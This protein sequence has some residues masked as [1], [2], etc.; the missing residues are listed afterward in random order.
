MVFGET[1]RNWAIT[2]GYSYSLVHAMKTAG[3]SDSEIAARCQKTYIPEDIIRYGSTD[4]V[5]QTV[6]IME[7]NG[8]LAARTHLFGLHQGMTYSRAEQIWDRITLGH[9]T[10]NTFTYENWKPWKDDPVYYVSE[11]GEVARHFL[12]SGLFLRL[13]P[14]I[15]KR[16]R[17]AGG[18][19]TKPGKRQKYRKVLVVKLRSGWITLA[20]L[21]LETFKPKPSPSHVV[22]YFG[23]GNP[24]NVRLEN[25]VWM[26]RNRAGQ[27]TGR[28]NKRARA[29]VYY[30][31]ETSKPITVYS[32]ARATAKSIGVSYQTVLDICNHKIKRPPSVPV[33]WRREKNGKK[34]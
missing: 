11:K 25:L 22:P 2:N 9:I 6:M 14:Y 27:I 16:A 31:I 17:N 26:T 28:K 19:K 7:K 8:K 18:R 4:V 33:R 30:D 15:A 23:D 20:R 3:A 21:L 34:N 1:A 5:A 12:K 10:G 32:S 24:L 13:Q 29:V